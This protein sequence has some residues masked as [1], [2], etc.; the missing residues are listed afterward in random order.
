VRKKVALRN[1]RKNEDPILRGKSRA[2]TEINERLLTLV[3]DM[4]E[5]IYAH[6][7]QGLAAP[8]VGV[9]KRVIVVD[10]GTGWNVFLNPEILERSNKK[11]PA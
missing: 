6:N 2:V 10:V 3:E 7:G 9:L 1:I 8:Q 4:K 5:T 11:R